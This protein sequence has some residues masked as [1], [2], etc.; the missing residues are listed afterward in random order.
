MRACTDIA[1][2]VHSLQLISPDAPNFVLGDLNHCDLQVSL[3]SFKQYVTVPTRKDSV[4]D[5]CY[6]NI[7][8]GYKSFSLPKIGLSDHETV[9]LVPS[10]KPKIQSEPV[11]TKSVKVWSD[12]VVETLQGC[13]DCTDWNVFLE[14]S[15]DVDEATDVVTEY[16]QFCEN[17][18]I[19]S[20]NVK[21][22][23]NNKPWVTK[24]LKGTI[25]EKK[26]AFQTGNKEERRK[27]QR[28]LRDEIRAAKLEYKQK[29]ERQFQSGEM[30]DAWKGLK[31]LTGQYTPC[32]SK[33]NCLC[34]DARRT[35]FAGE[36]NDF[37]CRFERDDLREDLSQTVTELRNR[38]VIDEGRTQTDLADFE[39]QAS[40]VESIFKRVIHVKHLVLIMYV[41]D[42]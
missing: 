25:N 18:I 37:Y 6:G 26:V 10:Y 1:D 30:R 7:K 13:L 31:A 24:A 32:K 5:R 29:V 23:P 14:S 15:V 2:V 28:K 22:Y 34:N 21:I 40:V 38:A 12:E 20:K 19:P 11:V 9:H 27:V 41:V 8:D 16:I 42:C 33:P 36:L 4:L 3:P 17:M 35:E 39:I